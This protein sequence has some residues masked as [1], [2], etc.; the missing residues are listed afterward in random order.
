MRKKVVNNKCLL[1]GIS[2]YEQDV[3]DS[4]LELEQ[5]CRTLGLEV[6]DKFYQKRVKPDPSY[7][8]GKGK[9]NKIKNFCKDENIEVV[10][11]NDEI[12]PAQKRNLEKFLNVNVLDRTQVIL[13]I[14]L[15]HATTNEGKLQ[16]EIAKLKYEL[17]YIVG[18]GKEFSR[19]GGGIATRGPGEQEAEYTK[20]YIKKRIRILTKKLEQIKKNREIK[21]KKRL[22]SYHGIISIVGYT[23]A[24]KSTLLAQ[25][26]QENV[27]IKNEMFST[28]APLL[29][30]VKLPSGRYVIFSDTVGF[31]KKLPHTL[32]ESFHSTLEEIVHSDLILI[33]LDVSDHN[34]QK[35]L[36]IV[37]EVLYDIGVYNKPYILV[38]NKIDL[39]SE[40]Y[41]SVVKK[42]Y[43]EAIYISAKKRQNIID[44][45]LKIDKFFDKME[46]SLILDVPFP[47]IGEVM[48]FRDAL[49]L[50]VIEMRNNSYKLSLKGPK[51]VL[52]QIKKTIQGGF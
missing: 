32:V 3:L 36:K 26:S 34:Y 35:K 4:L 37:H 45:L 48:K 14:F 41:L 39:C 22:E 17:P 8:L 10:V 51:A 50:N 12:T 15:K 47:K 33:L 31:I 21:R 7:Y 30:K 49:N 27:L 2:G 18:K 1:I 43:P 25:L 9:L 6:V 13:R 19:L 40:D 38:F 44:L 28:L 24:G 23:N 46:E 11:T 42:N 16:V 52:H 5:L 20:R 29:R